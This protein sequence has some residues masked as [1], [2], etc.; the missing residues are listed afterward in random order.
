MLVVEDDHALREIYRAAL[1]VAGYGVLA[2]EDGIDA[3]R[4]VDKAPPNLIVLDLVLPRLGAITSSAS[5]PRTGR[6]ET[7]LK[8]G[9][10]RASCFCGT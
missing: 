5:S 2:V 1:S 6:P 7:A 8:V 3:F 9:H 4:Q 10:G